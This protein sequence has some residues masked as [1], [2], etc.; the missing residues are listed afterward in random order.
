MTLEEYRSTKIENFFCAII[1]RKMTWEEA[2]NATFTVEGYSE[3]MTTIDMLKIAVEQAL[4]ENGE[5]LT[6]ENKKRVEEDVKSKI[7]PHLEAEYNVILL[8]RGETYIDLSEMKELNMEEYLIKAL[9]PLARYCKEE[10]YGFDEDESGVYFEVR[11][12]LLEKFVEDYG[13]LF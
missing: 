3:S 13:E 8:K 10:D 4:Q 9:V 12:E 7:L 11:M 5:M 1:V 2:K 6:E